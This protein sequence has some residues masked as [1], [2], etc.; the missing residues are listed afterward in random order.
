MAKRE[1]RHV[2]QAC[3]AVH[4]KWMGRCEACGAWNSVVE[5]ATESI[6]PKGLGVK[7]GRALHFEALEGESP[8]PPRALTGLMLDSDMTTLHSASWTTRQMQS[9]W[10]AGRHVKCTF[11]LLKCAVRELDNL[12]NAKSLGSWPSCE[13]RI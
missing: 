13:M 6:Q 3:G 7:G 4:T 2:C 10:E 5:E 9:R 1:N 11:E 12:P 8:S